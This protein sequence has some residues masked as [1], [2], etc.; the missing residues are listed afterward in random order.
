MAALVTVIMPVY[1]TEKYLEKAVCS[2]LSQTFSDFE[3]IIINNGST[4]GAGKIINRLAKKDN[5]IK[6]ITNAK[7][8]LISD[9]RNSAIELAQGKYICFVDSDD[10]IED[11]MLEDMVCTAEKFSAD[12][13]ISGFYM[14]YFQQ[15]KYS[16]FP[17][18]AEEKTYS[19]ESFKK[20]AY[21]LLNKTLLAVPWNKLY[22]LEHITKNNIK[23]RNTKW[24]DHHFNMDYLINTL[25][26]FDRKIRI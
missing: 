25:I 8:K 26:N 9:A 10:W 13:V 11:S 14:E 15:G 19:K 2:I 18:I 23:F 3:F 12:L 16:C 7:N 20:D 4:D 17:V 6:V 24:E 21:I 5:R 1:N 22:K